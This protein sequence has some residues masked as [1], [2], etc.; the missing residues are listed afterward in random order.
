MKKPKIYWIFKKS[1]SKVYNEFAPMFDISDVKPINAAFREVIEK[2]AYDKA[3]IFIKG[4]KEVPVKDCI[5]AAQP[6]IQ[7]FSNLAKKTLIELGELKE[8]K[9]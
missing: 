2:S 9:A 4:I 8:P 7:S 3:I 5:E 1:W 6:M